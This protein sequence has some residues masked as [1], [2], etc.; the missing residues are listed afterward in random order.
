[1]YKEELLEILNNVL[2][3]D[4]EIEKIKVLYSN[5]KKTQIGS[6][7]IEDEIIDSE[8]N[9]SSSTFDWKCI[10]ITGAEKAGTDDVAISQMIHLPS[11]R[12]INVIN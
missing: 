8:E 1:M 2:A 11:G 7:G 6:E 12:K 10:K 5:G 4:A 9:N 3:N